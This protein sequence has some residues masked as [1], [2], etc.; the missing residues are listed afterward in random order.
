MISSL[1]HGKL[2]E[3]KPILEES[4]LESRYLSLRPTTWL[5]I[6]QPID[7]LAQTSFNGQQPIRYEIDDID[8]PTP[9]RR[10]K[11]IITE[12]PEVTFE[13]LQMRKY[14][15]LTDEE[16]KARRKALDMAH[17]IRANIDIRPLTTS[18]II[19]QVR[20]GTEGKRG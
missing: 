9:S 10:W 15:K 20:E 2:P 5:P 7:Y 18:T 8:L 4:L 12:H 1:L 6:V 14:P 16:I 19:R 3:V 13:D 11:V 17:L